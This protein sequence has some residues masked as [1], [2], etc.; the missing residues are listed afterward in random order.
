VPVVTVFCREDERRFLSAGPRDI[1]SL[2]D[3]DADARFEE[4]KQWIVERDN[5]ARGFPAHSVMARSARDTMGAFFRLVSRFTPD[6]RFHSVDSYRMD[7]LVTTADGI[8][9]LDDVGQGSAE[10]YGWVGS[11][12]R[13]LSEIYSRDSAPWHQ[14]A[15][16]LVDEIDAHLHPSR[17]R[18]LV[19]LLRE[20]FPS[21]QFVATTH[22]PLVASSLPPQGLRVFRRETD[23]ERSTIALS[24]TQ[25]LGMTA[26][27]ILT[28]D[29]F[30]L[31]DTRS[32]EVAKSVDRYAFLLGRAKRTDMEQAEFAELGRRLLA[33]HAKGQD[34]LQRLVERM[35]RE[36]IMAVIQAKDDEAAI[37][38]L[39]RDVIREIRRRLGQMLPDGGERS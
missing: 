11:L 16:V 17:Q 25:T 31:R 26:D 7:V 14:F 33:V 20:A 30:G 10:L 28:S 21:V 29:L 39:P 1:R 4:L 18:M 19:P 27:Q 3:G 24:E 36:T 22:S 37:A 13:R 9:S 34:E 8:V 32:P 12:L 38:D 23:A 2:A 6:V 15:L 5:S 35:V